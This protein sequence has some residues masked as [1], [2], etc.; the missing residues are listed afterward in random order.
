M[1]RQNLARHIY[2]VLLISLC[3]ATELSDWSDLSDWSEKA[4][5]KS[6]AALKSRPKSLKKSLCGHYLK[7]HAIAAVGILWHCYGGHVAHSL[8]FKSLAGA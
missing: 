8:V 3:A 5:E 1:A 2:N 6:A 7:C 4:A